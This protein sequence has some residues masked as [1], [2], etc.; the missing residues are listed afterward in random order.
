MSAN[1]D[2]LAK[3]LAARKQKEEFKERGEAAAKEL[4]LVEPAPID[5]VPT[6]AK[7]NAT[8]QLRINNLTAQLRA[9]KEANEERNNEIIKEATS[10]TPS[11]ASKPPSKLDLLKA[12]MAAKK[13]ASKGQSA[14]QVSDSSTRSSSES[15]SRGNEDTHKQPGN[16][17][18]VRVPSKGA[19]G[20]D[21]LARLRAKKAAKQE[22]RAPD[23]QEL[24]KKDSPIEEALNL[25][26][27]TDRYGN[28]IT[29]NA[30]QQ[31]FIDLASSGSSCVLIGPA[32]TGKTTCMQGAATS[33]IDSGKAGILNSDGHKYL[34]SGTPGIIV[35]AYTRR[36]VNNIKKVLPD[37]LKR[38]CIT[39][40]KLLEYAPERT[41]VT[42]PE[43]GIE[44]NSMVFLPTRHAGHPLPRSIHTIIVEESSM[45]SVELYAEI[46]DAL[47]HQV[48]F[49]FLGD[50]QQLP[51]VFGS[52]ILGF[53]LLKLPVVE[54]TQVYRQAL[55][56]PIIRLAHHILSGKEIS[57]E[58]G[59][60]GKY[61]F[62]EEWNVPGKLKLHPWNKRN[63]DELAVR[64]LGV[65]VTKA[66]DAGSYNV[67]E[68]VI[69]IPYNKACGTLEL[70]RIIANHIARKERKV[71]YEVM[72]GF[73]KLYFSEG[74]KVLYEKEDAEIVEIRSNAGYSGA[75]VQKESVNLDYWG[76]NQK[77]GE[78]S[79][80]EP[81]DPEFL[82]DSIDIGDD[83]SRVRQASH[84]IVLNLL[85]S[86]NQVEVKSAAEINAL[87]HAYALTVHKAQ[88]SE[89]R[90]V[91]LF[92]HQSH[93]TMLQRELLYT[94]ITRA[95]EELY[96]ICE[97]DSLEKGIRK[98]RITGNTLEEKA[99]FFKGKVAEGYQ[100][101]DYLAK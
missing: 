5:K 101:P 91:F 80:S 22:N 53:K 65:F 54:L 59:S 41:T 42:D 95:K 77:P 27:A 100:L 44:R 9:N 2:K 46:V 18:S 37:D 85:D 97:Q 16:G 3:L 4:G 57:T 17:N 71:T 7:R 73:N 28:T 35:I 34:V 8:G 19:K 62:P 23:L 83:D 72:A 64:T 90:K 11:A 36:A 81:I 40:H 49:I 32:G 50:I 15:N 14:A 78:R 58:K 87:I 51:P 13:E 1:K 98:Q 86:G 21:F 79:S 29:Y 96:V 66:L 68:D 82:L 20:N 75:S 52:A 93:N 67:D 89:W 92:L 76:C 48:Q 60:D 38:N 69:L 88:G 84:V 55:E 56:S 94:G 24:H 31:E 63:K 70:N 47:G 43:T 12:S 33:L 6:I 30:E 26:S 74:D 39:A 45:L 10:E 61:H 25:G 99:E